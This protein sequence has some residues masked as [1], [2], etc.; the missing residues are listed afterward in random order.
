MLSKLTYNSCYKTI[1]KIFT[2]IACTKCSAPCHKFV[3]QKLTT[4]H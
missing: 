1:R 2:P 3:P 4:K